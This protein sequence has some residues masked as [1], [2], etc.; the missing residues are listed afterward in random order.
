MS[1]A[2]Q[3]RTEHSI[4]EIKPLSTHEDVLHIDLAV[5]LGRCPLAAGPGRSPRSCLRPVGGS[6]GPGGRQ[7]LVPRDLQVTKC[8][9][10]A[11]IPL[12]FGDS[13][14]VAF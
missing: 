6:V 14:V 11:P 10:D 3:D 8:F 13:V 4:V 5:S 2:E 7:K 12:A 9:D 1:I